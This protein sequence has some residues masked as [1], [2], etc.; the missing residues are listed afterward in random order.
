MFS[1]LKRT[2][3]EIEDN[4]WLTW[5]SKPRW[6]NVASGDVGET[7][8]QIL[9]TSDHVDQDLTSLKLSAFFFSFLLSFLLFPPNESVCMTTADE[10]A[11]VSAGGEDK[12]TA[13]IYCT[14]CDLGVLSSSSFLIL[15]FVESPEKL[16]ILF[17]DTELSTRVVNISP[18]QKKQKRYVL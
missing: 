8:K 16:W 4:S 12:H 14:F 3:R 15:L 11:D 6:R 10:P 5:K 18:A 17:S 2:N 1:L 13:C 9:V 7:E